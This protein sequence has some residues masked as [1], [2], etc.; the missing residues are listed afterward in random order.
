MVAHT[1]TGPGLRVIFE[2]GDRTIHST[3]ATDGA[4]ARD[5]A[6]ILIGREEEMQ[7][8]DKLTVVPE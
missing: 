6:L 2:R 3:Y 7:A 4:D 1:R 5:L 8:G